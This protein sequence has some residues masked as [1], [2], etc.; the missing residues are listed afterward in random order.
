VCV[1]RLPR[2]PSGKLRRDRLRDLVRDAAAQA[3]ARAPRAFDPKAVTGR[4]G[5][6]DVHV[7][8]DL[9]YFEGHFEGD[10][11]LPGVVQLEVLVARQVA[12]TWPD[13]ARVREITRLR[14][15]A[16]IRPG[17][18][19]LLI[20]ARPAPDRVE[21]EVKRGETSCSSGTLHFGT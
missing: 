20:L 15:R 19:L 8:S 5:V 14:F 13:L 11:I 1:D 4:P 18:D 3:R 21:F 9:A 6:F 7:P 12:A 16:P 2:E 17:D 10:P